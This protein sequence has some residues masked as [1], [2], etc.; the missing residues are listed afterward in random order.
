MRSCVRTARCAHPLL[1][2]GDC[3]PARFCS[4]HR[5]DR[6][7]PVGGHH[8]NHQACV[9]QRVC[10]LHH[11]CLCQ[12]RLGPAEDSA[13]PTG[14]TLR[15]PPACAP[16]SSLHLEALLIP[17][18]AGGARAAVSCLTGCPAEWRGLL[19]SGSHLPSLQVLAVGLPSDG[20]SR[21]LRHPAVQGA[22]RGALHGQVCHFCQD[23]RPPRRA[24]ALLLH[25]G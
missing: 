12:V 8:R 21:E 17:H 23:E 5:R 15:P 3:S 24:S 20:R 10:H 6:P 11:Q 14:A 25:D 16:A 2:S 7:G 19:G 22:H 13:V 1:A 4:C 9:R 18:S